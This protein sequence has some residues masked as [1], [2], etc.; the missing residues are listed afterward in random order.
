MPK[1]PLFSFVVPVYKKPP[2]VFRRCLKD[3]LNSTLKEIEVIAVFD[4]PDAELEKVVLEFPLV[5]VFILEHGGGSRARNFG[6]DKAKGKYLWFWDADCY[7]KPDHAKRMLQ[8]F[9]ATDAD[10]VYAGYELAEGQGE[11]VPEP[12]DAY[13]LQ[14]GNYISSMAPIKR[15]KAPRWDETLEAAQDWD[16]WLTAVDMGLKGVYVEGSGFITDTANTGL[17]SVKWSPENR[18]ETIYRVRRKHGIPDREMG[19]YSQNYR[20]MGI[21]LA[22]IIGADIIKPTGPTVTKYKLILNLGYSMM[23]RFEGFSDDLIKI[24]YWLPGEVEG[25]RAPDAKYATVLETVRV[26]KTVINYCGTQYE[27]NKLAE[28]GI[29]AEVMPLPLAKEDVNKVAKTLPEKF[30]ILVST[31]KA[32]SDLL[33][34]LAN[35]LPHINFLYNAAKVSDFSCFLSFYQFAALDHAML[36][37][38]VNGRHV[39]SNVQAPYCGFVD[40]DQSWEGFKK[41]LFDKIRE[42]SRKAFNDEAQTYYLEESN[43]DRFTRAVQELFPRVLEV[44]S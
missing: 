31:D 12:F 18:D 24:Q 1:Q 28:I 38:H 25:I 2:E 9:E 22:K 41:D 39:I 17:S 26:A 36:T 30:T 16:Y 20:A 15:D 40:P 6:M 29:K 11:F 43:P 10:F 14:T 34:D 37:A 3:L 35:D 5:R 4:G 23:S 33:K 44:V 21:K 8:E 27:A 19:V 32:Y 42:V 7:I 13:S